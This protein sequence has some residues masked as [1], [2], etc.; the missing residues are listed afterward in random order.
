MMTV[1]MIPNL[2]KPTLN[3]DPK[4]K[5]FIKEN[6][7]DPDM[8]DSI[9]EFGKANVIKGVN[10]YTHL[11]EISFHACLLPLNH[12]SHVKLADT[13]DE[14][15]KHL[16]MPI[17]FVEPYELKRYTPKDFFG[18][19]TDNYFCHKDG[20]DRK[21]TFSIQ[22][23]DEIDFTGGDFLILNQS[24]PRA[25]GSIVAFPSFFPHEVKPIDTGIRW[26]LISWAWGKDFT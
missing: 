16:N 5:I 19:H 9:I 10:K 25:K 26:S 3:F 6:V 13:W 24:G 8:C 17:D 14:V 21:I 1:N 22:L 7:L 11:F 18:K 2:E 12:E 20:I 23:T 15:S 4:R